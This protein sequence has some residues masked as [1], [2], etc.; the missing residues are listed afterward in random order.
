MDNL[1]ILGYEVSTASISK[2]VDS[3]LKSSSTTVLNTINP[4]SYVVAKSDEKFSIALKDSDVLIPDGSGI[5]LAASFIYKVEL[6]KIAGIDLFFETMK[7]LEESKGSVFFLGSSNNVLAKIEKR[8]SAQF[9]NVTID[10]LSPPYKSDFS[11]SDLE[12]FENKINQ[13][14]PDVVFVGLT[15]PKQEKLIHVLKHNINPKLISGIGA[16]FDFYAGTVKRPSELWIKMHLEWLR[17]LCTEP[18]R[19]WRRNFISTP[20][21]LR[22]MLICKVFGK[23]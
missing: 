2:L 18:K 22:D 20:V 3:A 16:V 5:S 14:C 15:A 10:V 9:P 1:N 17:R 12:N 4:H 6:K 11:E 7:Q 13:A 8:I 23:K 21:F 19:L